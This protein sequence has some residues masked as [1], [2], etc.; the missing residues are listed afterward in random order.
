MAKYAFVEKYVFLAS[1]LI[2]AIYGIAVGYMVTKQQHA[3]RHIK[4]RIWVNHI[5]FA[6]SWSNRVRKHQDQRGHFATY[7]NRRFGHSKEEKFS[8]IL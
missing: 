1:V 2:T 4:K 7:S 3:R 5:C 6:Y 8:K